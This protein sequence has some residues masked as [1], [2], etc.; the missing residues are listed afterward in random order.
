MHIIELEGEEWNGYSAPEN[1]AKYKRALENCI[2]Y[3]AVDGDYICG[4]SRSFNDNE[5][6][7]VVSDLLV[8][9][10]YRGLG[11]GKKL[12]DILNVDYTHLKTYVMSDVDEYY[13][14]QGYKV[15][16]TVFEVG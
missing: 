14:K 8:T 1:Q 10:K 13:M 4:Y 7:I 16:G 12:M 2:V 11:L 3:V 9:P 15:V 6:F 5:L